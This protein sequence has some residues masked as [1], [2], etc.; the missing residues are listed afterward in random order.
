MGIS[1]F[2][3]SMSLPFF[4]CVL[5]QNAKYVL[6]AA[7]FQYFKFTLAFFGLQILLV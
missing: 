6:I 2:R 5:L 3:R 1:R 7:T 4:V